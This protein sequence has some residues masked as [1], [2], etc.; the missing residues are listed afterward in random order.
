[1]ISVSNVT[2]RFGSLS[3][4]R[5]VSLELEAKR[6]TALI[7]PSGCGKS[8]LLRLMLGLVEADE[9]FVEFD[10]KRLERSNRLGVR[11][12]VGYAIQSGGLFPHMTAR[13]N[14]A[15]PGRRAGWPGAKLD[16]R[17]DELSG[18]MHLSADTLSR[19]PAELSGGQR[20]RVALMRALVLDP[21]VLLL[22]E[23]LG[24]LDPVIR[25]ELQHELR[26]VFDRLGKTVVLVTHDLAE[27][28]YLAPRDI[29]LMRDGEIVQRGAFA[30][31]RDEPAEPF[32]ERFIAAQTERLA[33]LMG[34]AA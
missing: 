16:A 8:T 5:D 2:V 31:L 1:M 34:G 10:G 18:L 6:T 24:A 7:G 28:S 29:V 3:A 13:R 14:V 23:P 21:E 25:G 4:L 12:R 11:Q 19:Y 26:E 33:G 9:G 27:A 15:F 17:I 22:D 20:Q 32:V 30:G